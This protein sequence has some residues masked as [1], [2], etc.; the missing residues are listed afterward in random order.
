MGV[1]SVIFMWLCYMLEE[2]E[3]SSIGRV[4]LVLLRWIKISLILG[5]VLAIIKVVVSLLKDTT[6]FI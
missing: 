1:G 4:I 6:T 2:L 5:I 3:E